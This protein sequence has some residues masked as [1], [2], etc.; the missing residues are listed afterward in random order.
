MLKTLNPGDKKASANVQQKNRVHDVA[1]DA[2]KKEREKKQAE[3][4]PNMADVL[5]ASL[6]P[7]K[8]GPSN[9]L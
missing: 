1:A 3:L 7:T 8:G 2:Q 9:K 5:K 6:T 4:K